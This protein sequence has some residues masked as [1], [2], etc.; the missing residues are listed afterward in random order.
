MTSIGIIGECMVELFRAEESSQQNE[1]FKK[2]FG[3]DTYNTAYYLAQC[4]RGNMEVSYITAL[5]DDSLSCEMI[6]TFAAAGVGTDLIEKIPGAVPGLYMIQTDEKG[7][8]SFLY[9]RAQAPA[10]QLFQTAFSEQL[11][12]GLMQKD[13]L[14]F[15]GITLAILYPEGR[16]ELFQLCRDFRAKGGKIAFDSNYRPRLWQDSDEAKYVLNQAYSLCDLALP[17]HDDEKLL[18]GLENTD[19]S[20]QRISK[21]GVHEIV[22]KNGSESVTIYTDG[23][24]QIFPVETASVIKDTTAAGDSFNAGYLWARLSGKEIG[25]SAATAGEIARQVIAQQGAIV[26][27]TVPSI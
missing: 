3:G 16:E 21:L 18:F 25:V 12:A 7:E 20:I 1:L 11:K 6:D 4:A 24:V 22:L 15:S 14:C 19:Q 27:I 26:P 5:G 2:R 10:R 17:S 8:R 13:W 23:D 9:W